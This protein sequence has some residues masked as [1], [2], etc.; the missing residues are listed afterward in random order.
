MGIDMVIN[1][2]DTYI[3]YIIIHV[4]DPIDATFGRKGY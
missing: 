3:K 4:Y 2:E 1:E